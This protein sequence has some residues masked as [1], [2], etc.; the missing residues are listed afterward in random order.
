MRIDRRTNLDEQLCRFG[1]ENE[2]V[3][4]ADV[5]TLDPNIPQREADI[6]Q[7]RHEQFVTGWLVDKIIDYHL[8]VICRNRPH[9]ILCVGTG[10]SG[11]LRFYNVD[12]YSMDNFR[13]FA[14]DRYDKLIVPC[15]PTANHWLLLVAVKHEAAVYVLDSLHPYPFFSNAIRRVVENLE[16]ILFAV[17]G[18]KFKYKLPQRTMQTNGRDCGIFACYYAYRVLSGG[19]LTESFDPLDLRKK[20]YKSILSCHQP[21]TFL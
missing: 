9:E 15:N 6:L 5:K 20:I 16:L 4:V 19:K 1:S 18:Q 21:Y 12:D 14:D 10:S 2:Y 13:A 8:H 3:T 17:T 7:Q 11:F